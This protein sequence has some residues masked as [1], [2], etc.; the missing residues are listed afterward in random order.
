MPISL[1]PATQ[2]VI[3]PDEAHMHGAYGVVL[4]INT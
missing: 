2:D 1:A 3:A 4:G